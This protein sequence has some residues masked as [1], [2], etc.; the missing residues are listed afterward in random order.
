MTGTVKWFNPKKGYGFVEG[1]DGNSYFCHYSDIME[2]G[3]KDLRD[4]EPVKFNIRHD[5][6]GSRAV[7]VR[8]VG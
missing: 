4:N 3:F 8:R 6:K 7:N 5:Q 2:K 1:S